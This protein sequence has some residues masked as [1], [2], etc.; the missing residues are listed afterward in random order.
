MWLSVRTNVLT[1]IRTARARAAPHTLKNK[2]EASLLSS[3]GAALLLA[4]TKNRDRWPDSVFYACAEYSFSIL[5]Q[6]ELTWSPWI[7]D[8]RCCTRSLVTILGAEQNESGLLVRKCI[9]IG[10]SLILDLQVMVNWQ[11]SSKV[12]AHQYHA[13]ICGLRLRAHKSHVLF[14][15]DRWPDEIR[16]YV[17]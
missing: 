4:S 14:K 9:T 16:P 5:S 1:Y 8:Y 6:S 11:L 15:I 7:T 10:T 2:R 3:P 17:R 13:F 12:F